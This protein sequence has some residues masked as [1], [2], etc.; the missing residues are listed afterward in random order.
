MIN[1]I[2]KNGLTDNEISDLKQLMR[3]NSAGYKVIKRIM[4]VEINSY[5]E[6]ARL[7]TAIQEQRD[8]ARAL[9]YAYRQILETLENLEK[10]IKEF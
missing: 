4:E 1:I 3:E 6:I 7:W 9:I 2:E 8:N 10:S 5:V